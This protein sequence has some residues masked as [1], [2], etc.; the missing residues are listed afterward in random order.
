M[1]FSKKMDSFKPGIFDTLNKL[2][3]NKISQG[4]KVYDLWVGT[5]DFTPSEHVMQAFI[6]AAK[7]PKNLNI[8]SATCLSLLKL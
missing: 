7:D 2:R 3:A 4:H 5:P 1:N 6:E 8:L